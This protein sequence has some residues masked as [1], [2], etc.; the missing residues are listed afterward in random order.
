[1]ATPSERLYGLLV[2][3]DED[4]GRGVVRGDP[5]AVPGNGVK[6]VSAMTLQKIGDRVVDAKT[7]LA[8]LFAAMGAPAFLTGL[9]VPVR[10]SGSLLPQ[11]ALVP[12]VRRRPRRKWVWIAGATGQA[13][14]V[15]AMA[16]LAAFGGGAAAGWGI[17]AALAVFSLSRSLSSIS[18]KDVLGR[19]IPKGQRGQISGAATVTSGLAAITVGVAIR[20]FGQ[21]AGPRT[22]AVLLAAAAT[23]W[24]LGLLVYATIREPAGDHDADADTSDIGRALSLL[25]DDPPFRRFVIARTL[26][27]V[28][29][30]APPFV[31]TIATRETGDAIAGLGP[32]VIAQG[33]ASL[34]GGRT[35]GRLADRSSRWVMVLASGLAATVVLLFLA[36]I[37]VQAVAALALT[38]PLVYFVLALL[39][40]GA[41]IGRKTY[42]VDLAEGDRRTEYVA[43]ANTAMGVLLLATGAVSAAIASLGVEAALAFLAVLGLAAV[44]VARSLP[45]VSARA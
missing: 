24:M 37:R 41:R 28:S 35:W 27:L 40:T 29:A 39:H 36:A 6:L 15:T 7:V 11:A 23:T 13:T 1:M 22:F 16:L 4:H 5:E 30:L 21:D 31:V 34:V 19:T 38:Y 2:D 33:V 25:R 44:P 9:L 20:V 45:E 12:F 17:L 26:L 32:F 43:V 8:W 3:D 10:E 14:A 42:V 18:S